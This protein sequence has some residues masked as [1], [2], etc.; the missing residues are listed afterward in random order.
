[1]AALNSRPTRDSPIKWENDHGLP[2]CNQQEEQTQEKGEIAMP[3][4]GKKHFSYG[5]KGKAKAKAYAKKTGKKVT[6]KK[7]KA[8]G[9]KKGY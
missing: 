6:K 4:V 3:R 1:M 8:K 9:R 2:L 7:S 5:P